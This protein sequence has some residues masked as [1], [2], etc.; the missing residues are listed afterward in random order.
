M[1]DT[2]K[3]I[4]E[5]T[6]SLAGD[7]EQLAKQAEAGFKSQWMSV[8]DS[9]EAKWG[10]TPGIY[11]GT[12]GLPA[13]ADLAKEGTAPEWAKEADEKAGKIRSAVERKMGIEEPKGFPQHLAR[14]AGEMVAQVPVPGAMMNKLRTAKLAVNEAPSLKRKIALS[15]LEYFSPIVEVGKPKPTAI[16]YGVGTAFGGGLGYGIEKLT[17]D[18]PSLGELISKYGPNYGSEV[19]DVSKPKNFAGGG[20]ATKLKQGKSAFFSAVDKAISTLKQEKGTPEQMM[21]LIEK[22]PGVKK[23]ELER[24]GIRKKLEGKK[25]ITRAELEAIAKELPAQAPNITRLK[26]SYSLEDVME[27]LKSDTGLDD[28][29]IQNIET[30]LGIKFD[31]NPKFGLRVAD[32]EGSLY[33]LDDLKKIVQEYRYSDDISE[34]EANDLLKDIKKIGP[35]F[36]PLPKPKYPSYA[37]KGLAN[38]PVDYQEVIMSMPTR[39]QQ[40]RE[41]A[42]QRGINN[43][44]EAERAWEQ[45]YGRP[46]PEDEYMGHWRDIPVPN[47]TVHYRTQ[48]FID[49]DGKKVLHVEEVQSD[50]HQKARD[51]RK[52]EILKRA[53]N[54]KDRRFRKLAQQ[55]DDDPNFLPEGYDFYDINPSGEM[56]GETGVGIFNT[57]TGVDLGGIEGFDENELKRKFKSILRQA[58]KQ[59]SA[60]SDDELKAFAK[61]VPDDFG[62]MTSEKEAKS[63]ELEKKIRQIRENGLSVDDIEEYFQPGKIIKSWSGTDK[64]LGF[65]RGPKP[66]SD[67]WLQEY[68]KA[69]AYVRQNYLARDDEHHHLMA[70]NIANGKANDW[71]V[72]VVEIDPATGKEIGSPRMHRTSPGENIIN[73][74]R[75]ERANLGGVVS[76][77]PYKKTYDELALKQII[78]DAVNQGYDRVSISPGLFQVDR[79]QSAIRSQIDGI[80]WGPMTDDG[81]YVSFMKD[82]RSI[83][84]VTVDESGKVLHGPNEWQGEPLK[85]VIGEDMASKIVASPERGQFSGEGLTIGAKG[86]V[87]F[88]D[89]RLPNFLREYL[90][91]EFGASTGRTEFEYDIGKREKSFPEI[92][93]EVRNKFLNDELTQDQL[94]SLMEFEQDF[95]FNYVNDIARSHGLDPDSDDVQMMAFNDEGPFAGV[96]ETMQNY[97]LKKLADEIYDAQPMINP[98]A[99]VFSFDITP[100]MSEKVKTQGQRLFAAAPVVALPMAQDDEDK[101]KVSPSYTIAPEAKTPTLTQ[102]EEQQFQ[103]DVRGTDWF[104]RFKEKFGEEPNLED[105]EYN[106]RAA[107]KS[108]AKPQAIDQD[109]IPH[110]PSVTSSGESL[111]ARSHPSGWMEDYMQITGRDPSEGGDLTPEQIDAMNKSLMYRY[112]FAKGGT[113]NKMKQVLKKMGADESKVASKDLTTMQDFHTSLGDSIRERAARMQQQMDAMQFKYEPGQHVFTEDSARKNFSPFKILNKTMVGNNPMREPHPDH[114]EL[115]KVIKDPVTGKTLRTPYEPGYKVRHERGP[116]D[117]SE[118]NIPES[119]I[120]GAVDFAKGGIAK[121]MKEA[122]ESKPSMSR[123]NKSKPFIDKVYS[124]YAPHPF[125]NTQR[126]I[127]EGEGEA[128]KFAQFELKPGFGND[129]VYIDWISAYPHR[130]GMGSRAISELQQHAQDAGV[131]LKLYPWDKGQVSQK[132]LTSFYKKMG[133]TPEVKGSKTLVWKPQETVEP[134]PEE[135]AKGGLAKKIR[136]LRQKM[137]N[138]TGEYNAKRLDRAADEVK[139][140]ADTFSSDALRRAF[141]GDNTTG[142]IIV[143]PGK[144][145]TLAAKLPRKGYDEDV[146]GASPQYRIGDR[147]VNYD[148]YIKH[149]QSIAQKTG[150]SDVPYLNLNKRDKDALLYIS[151]HEGRHRQRALAD[152]GDAK[153]LVRIEPRAAI[154]EP[155][156]RR[157]KEQG[158][159]GLKAAIQN[160]PVKSEND[161]IIIL[162]EVFKHGGRV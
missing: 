122:L 131:T 134:P 156:E 60:L 148:E 73:E 110:W 46:L 107:W 68:D 99:D 67:E 83:S 54:E 119:A 10:G 53:E 120:K 74:L 80:E 92:T 157:T 8:D 90:R 48:A 47:Y 65:K 72:Q 89:K 28:L 96:R 41:F 100:E 26:D 162:P 25:S 4:K 6:K 152:L 87:E 144:Y 88:Y 14:A 142:L 76:D 151:G 97:A 115:G 135:F 44:Q 64:V 30:K 114:P 81:R 116:D 42:N 133:F 78:D 104:S 62:Y 154:R 37:L 20:K 86:F 161:E 117:W 94:D 21:S 109:D 84:D 31:F 145:E 2:V 149:L 93:A 125:F 82:G 101:R 34:T 140:L 55:L 9:G 43:I 79:Y 124:Q 118:F 33:N 103:S 139:N 127:T 56:G 19:R 111:K 24:R 108:G 7:A 45:E 75:Q 38:R 15:P 36:D 158:I 143:D 102:D 70:L 61:D 121:K 112:G 95:F 50:P 129:E 52:Q 29:A 146:H 147:L 32:S 132:A 123:E 39:M 40:L 130:S 51:V 136:E 105:K 150:F 57:R 69:L 126:V 138:E 35:Y 3:R 159:E 23:E 113:A 5:L 91:K 77:L 59:Q 137:A 106:Y 16:N 66:D 85:N 128:Q 98:K 22:T 63:N 12:V 155:I 13:L 141:M 71:Q 160:K 17:D 58:L 11:Y 18:K 27:K 1:G 49:K 153:S